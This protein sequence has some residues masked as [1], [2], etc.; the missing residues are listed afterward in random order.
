MPLFFFI[1]KVKNS[2]KFLKLHDFY[3]QILKFKKV[4]IEYLLFFLKLLNELNIK[5]E[6]NE[7]LNSNT[8]FK[9]YSLNHILYYV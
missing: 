3:E 2:Y 8:F 9:K 6:L 7:I 5:N 4:A 1:L